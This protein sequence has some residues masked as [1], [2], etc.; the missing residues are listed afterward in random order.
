MNGCLDVHVD[1]YLFQVKDAVND[2][3]EFIRFVT[4]GLIIVAAIHILQ[5]DDINGTV[6][7]P[8]NKKDHIDNVAS[9]IVEYVKT[10]QV[11]FQNCDSIP[12][13]QTGRN[14]T[15][16]KCGF[17][18]C[19]KTFAVDGRCRAKHREICPYKDFDV[20]QE[21]ENPVNPPVQNADDNTPSSTDAKYNYTC[22]LLRD[23][24]MDWNRED[25][26]KENDGPRLVRMWRFDMLR[27]S[28]AN[29]TKY[30]LLAFRL[31]A[32]L[33]ALLPP[34]MA[35]QLLHN[36]CVNIHG[37]SAKNVPGDL[38]L[39]F[40]N[41]RAKDALNSLHGNLTSASIKRVGR[42]LQGC[43]DIVDAY[44]SGLEQYFGKPANSKPSLSGD[45]RKFVKH[46]EEHDL[47]TVIPGRY[48]KSFKDFSSNP[49]D[50]LNC[51]KLKNW[52][53]E[54]KE[55]YSRSQRTRSYLV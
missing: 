23:G 10:E 30:R 52:I 37:G 24:L 47:F 44:T 38:A 16:V 25:A 12:Q 9:K 14:G 46:V 35:H 4:K 18:G 8:E 21:P 13:T 27:Y 34:K 19:P 29:H 54:K 28:V 32:Q 48:H 7:I 17:P 45:N 55:E 41:M 20:L 51:S 11:N 31:Q 15:R 42:S 5:L 40:M 36:R 22:S 1:L 53:R 26:A 3:R 6:P 49:L 33:M 43:N 2:C 50:K 39:E